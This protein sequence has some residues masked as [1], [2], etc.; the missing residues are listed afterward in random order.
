VITYSAHGCGGMQSTEIL[1]KALRKRAGWE[2]LIK[3]DVHGLKEA[4][5]Q[6]CYLIQDAFEWVLCIMGIFR[7]V[8]IG[9]VLSIS[10]LSV[11]CSS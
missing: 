3:I 10:S 5:Y 2:E 7:L 1:A 4:E 6:V 9:N 8:I 11:W